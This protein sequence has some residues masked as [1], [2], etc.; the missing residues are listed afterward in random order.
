MLLH[1][2]RSH[3]L[4][5]GIGLGCGA[6]RA[7]TSHELKLGVVRTSAVVPKRTSR[8]PEELQHRGGTR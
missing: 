8:S 7:F 6:G 2:A 5:H 1:K 3:C 4:A